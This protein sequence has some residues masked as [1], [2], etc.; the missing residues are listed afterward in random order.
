MHGIIS[1][2]GQGVPQCVFQEDVK[3]RCADVVHGTVKAVVLK[4]YLQSTDL[5]VSSCY[6]QKPFYMLS[7]EANKITWTETTKKITAPA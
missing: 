2:K 3:E 6:D 5:V 4:G 1:K 7:N